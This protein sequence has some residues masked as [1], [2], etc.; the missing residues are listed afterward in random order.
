M[1][2][3]RDHGQLAI[4]QSNMHHSMYALCQDSKSQRHPI[5]MARKWLDKMSKIIEI[6]YSSL[7]DIIRQMND[8]L[9]PMQDKLSNVSLGVSPIGRMRRTEFIGQVNEAFR[10]VM[11][12]PQEKFDRMDSD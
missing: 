12:P 11:W 6:N 9:G 8:T 10:S 7:E 5:N 2:M 3:R 4:M 1:E